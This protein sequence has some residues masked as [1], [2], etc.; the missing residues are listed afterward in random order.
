VLI[1]A[2]GAFVIYQ[3]LKSLRPRKLTINAIKPL[4]QHDQHCGC[5][6]LAVAT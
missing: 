4:Y 6:H 5:G 2:F 1:G 3:A